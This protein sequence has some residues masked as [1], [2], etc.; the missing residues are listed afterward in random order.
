MHHS[1]CPSTDPT[2]SSEQLSV[3]GAV[4][5]GHGS[6]QTLTALGLTVYWEGSNFR[7]LKNKHGLLFFK[8]DGH[9]HGQGGTFLVYRTVQVGVT[10]KVALE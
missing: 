7:N 4:C 5:W 3:L 2:A 6:E 1:R 10:E 9:S 8:C